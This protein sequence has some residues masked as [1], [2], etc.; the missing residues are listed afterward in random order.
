MK[1]YFVIYKFVNGACHFTQ[2][3]S[4]MDKHYLLS[5]GV[6]KSVYTVHNLDMRMVVVKRQRL[7]YTMEHKRRD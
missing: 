5:G 2:N 6:L 1:K 4:D 3:A 7:Q